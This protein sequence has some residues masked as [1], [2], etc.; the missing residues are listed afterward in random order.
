MH[1]RKGAVLNRAE[2]LG[3]IT[4]LFCCVPAI[5]DTPEQPVGLILNAGGSKLVRLNTET[6]LA[7]RAGDLLFSGDR[8]KTESGA[9][10]FLYCPAT[11]M[12]TLAPAGEVHLVGKEPK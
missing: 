4:L 9:A 11:S 5:A 8:L 3:S 2:R 7:A 1:R 10:A 12:E 6:P